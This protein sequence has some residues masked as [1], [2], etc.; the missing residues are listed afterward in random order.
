MASL[1]IIEFLHR[2]FDVFAEYFGEVSP[3]SL[4]DNF[5]TA[6]QLLEEMLDNGHPVITEPNALQTLI[7]PPTIA[8]K[9]A[10]FVMGKASNVSDTLGEGAMSVIPWRRAGVKYAAN[11]IYFD[12]IEEVDAIY[13]AN[14]TLVSSDVRG[15]VTC[16]SHMSG[17]PDLTLLFNAPGVIEDCSFHPC[18]RYGRWERESVVSFVPPDGPFTLMTYRLTDRSPQ[19]PLVC[20]PAVSWRADSSGKAA[21][22]LTTKP[23]T[24]RTAG[25]AGASLVG[26]ADL[27]VD[28]VRLVV[29]FPRAVKTVDLVSEAGSVVTDP[30]TNEVTWSLRSMPRDRSPELAGSLFLPPGA[31]API[32]PVSATLHY[33]VAGHTVSGLSIKDLLL[34]GAEKYKFF[35]G[36]RTFLR[37]G[38]VQIRT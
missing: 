31:A 5:S 7:A 14:G 17:V 2:V 11:E 20:R 30:K 29:S 34:V 32:E 36:V 19:T 33:T 12:I 21:F 3:R 15:T 24:A 10:S 4:T 8:G 13:E 27:S 26:G 38:R 6:Y 22:T 25:G 28:D 9:V 18:V 35:K 1:S 23:M 37:S 16:N